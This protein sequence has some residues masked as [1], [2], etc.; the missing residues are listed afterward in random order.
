MTPIVNDRVALDAC[1]LLQYCACWSVRLRSGA[2]A[3]ST[4]R[5]RAICVGLAATGSCHSGT[6]DTEL[7]T[8]A[9]TYHL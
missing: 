1:R 4:P 3:A 7:A 8:G 9:S 2:A 5:G 6:A